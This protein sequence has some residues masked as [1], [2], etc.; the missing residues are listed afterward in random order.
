VYIS[1]TTAAWITK[2]S[3]SL[4]AEPVL[5]AVAI[6]LKTLLHLLPNL[7]ERGPVPPFSLCLY[8]MQQ[9][10]LK[11]LLRFPTPN[12]I[13]MHLFFSEM[14]KSKV[15]VKQSYYRLRQALRVPGV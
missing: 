2:L 6:E 13:E 10:Y 4:Q 9:L 14:E 15:K 5:R 1:V 12:F 7:R 3:L 11:Y 8:G